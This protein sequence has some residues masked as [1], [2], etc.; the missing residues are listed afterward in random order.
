MSRRLAVD[1]NDELAE[2]QRTFNEML[3]RLDGA[4][5]QLKE[6]VENQRRFT[7][8]AS[9]ELRTPLTKILLAASGAKEPGANPMEA[10]HT[11]EVAARQMQTLVDQ[12]LLLSRADSGQL[13]LSL[14]RLDLRV[15]VAE[16]VDELPDASARV[17]ATFPEEA[18]FVLGDFDHLRRCFRNLVENALRY[19]APDSQVRV[20]V[21]CQADQAQVSVEDHGIGI[22]AADLLRLGERFFRANPARTHGEGTGL[23]L[24]IAKTIVQAHQGRLEFQS[25]EGKGTTVEVFLPAS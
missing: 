24:A 9:H 11:V 13:A 19:S 1:G 7:A 23:G 4:F 5:G 8:D 10:A 3:D 15:L 2:L 12:L 21:T 14:E 25:A 20:Q 16:A 22:G 17:A 6:S 18:V